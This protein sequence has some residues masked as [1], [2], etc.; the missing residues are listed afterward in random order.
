MTVL[1]IFYDTFIQHGGFFF[2]GTCILVSAYMIRRTMIELSQ[3]TTD[4]HSN[5]T[6]TKRRLE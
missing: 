6:T 2:V 1:E 3:S 4:N 5:T